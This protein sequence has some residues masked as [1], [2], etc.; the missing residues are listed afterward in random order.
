MFT[1]EGYQSK[2]LVNFVLYYA[3]K[4]SYSM[5]S[6]LTE[7]RCA[8][9]HMSD[10][11][12]QSMVLQKA[13]AIGK[14]QQKTIEEHAMSLPVMLED[15]DIYDS[16]HAEVLWLEDG[17]CVSKQKERRDKVAKEG[18]Q[19]TTTDSIIFQRPNGSFE[20]IVAAN[21]VDLTALAE[22]TLKAHY[23]NRSVSIVVLSDGA[24][25]IK[26]RCLSLFGENYR[27]ILDWYHLQKKVREL[28]TMIAPSKELKVKYVDEILGFLWQG[29]IVETLQKLN[30]YTYRNKTKWEELI[31]YLTKNENH[32]IDYKKRKDS[33]KIIGSGRMEKMGDYLV[34]RRQKEKAMSWSPRGSNALALLAAQ[35]IN[36]ATDY[37]Q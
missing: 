30:S 21:G 35:F 17:V 36:K 27:H 28:M 25:T 32:I 16:T 22:A 29:R 26:N 8:G 31:G 24:R 12:I 20:T 5:V 3:T 6:Q 9:V 33:G 15:C 4:V 34:A 1:T 11:H 19:R 14:N 23:A 37:L 10:Q 18:K 7:Q 13:E 2:E